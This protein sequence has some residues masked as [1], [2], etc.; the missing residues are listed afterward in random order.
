MRTGARSTSACCNRPSGEIRTVLSGGHA[1]RRPLRKCGLLSVSGYFFGTERFSAHAEGA[2]SFQG[3]S[4]SVRSWQ[5]TA[6]LT[7]IAAMENEGH[8][9]RCGFAETLERVPNEPPASAPGDGAEEGTWRRRDLVRG[10]IRLTRDGA[11]EPRPPPAGPLLREHFRERRRVRVEAGGTLGT[12]RQFG[13]LVPP[14]RNVR[15]GPSRSQT[16]AVQSGDDVRRAQ[17]SREP[18]GAHRCSAYRARAR[19]TARRH[20]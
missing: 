13:Q 3:P 14:L 9:Y 17:G 2:P 12:M 5:Y 7:G 1:S 4:R 6:Y 20:K 15:T 10:A 18:A 19:S 11:R 8:P 16:G